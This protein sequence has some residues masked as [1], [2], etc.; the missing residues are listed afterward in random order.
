MTPCQ[1]SA[2]IPTARRIVFA[3]RGLNHLAPENTFP[4]FALAADAG[5]PWLEMDVDIISDGTPVVIHDST[6]DRTTNRGG[7]IYRL[8]ASEL[9]EIDAGS[10]FDPQFADT[11]LPRFSDFIHFLNEREMNCN[12]ELKQ[13]ELGKEST[14]RMIDSVL[15]ALEELDDQ[16]EIIVSSF[17]PLLLAA[18]HERAPQYAIGMLWETCALYDDWLSVLEMTGASY[19]HP[20]DKG[21]TADRV[22][23]FVEAGYGVNVWTVNDA[24]RANQLFNWGA[25][26]VFTDV[27][28]QLLHLS[29]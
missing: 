10:W 24:D 11:T 26:G 1:P 14:L 7:S 18:F 16:R 29:A 4:A 17:S 15:G 22:T 20:E 3:H 5:V 12:I 25:T 23:Q 8:T 21:L 2:H 6:L 13:H 9:E 28:D 19:V 27:A